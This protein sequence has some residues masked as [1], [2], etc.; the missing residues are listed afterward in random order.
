M[1]SEIVKNWFAEQFEYLDPLLQQLHLTGGQLVGDVEIS[2]GIGLAHIIGARFARKM[3]LPAAGKHRLTVDISHNQQALLW[4]RSFNNQTLV[5]SIFK[6]VGTMAD[7]YWVEETGNLSMQL[8]V[9]IKDAGWY[10]RCLSVKYRGVSIP[11]WLVP[12]T[13]AYKLVEGGKYRFYV[14]VSL[15]L[16]GSLFSYQ[17]LLEKSAES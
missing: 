15:P 1:P 12:K 5:Y 17:G 11:S 14:E 6:P 3:N 7:G 8:A 9:E 16:V 10:W 4:G 2:Y 13:T